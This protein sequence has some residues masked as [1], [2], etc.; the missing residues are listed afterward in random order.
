MI[1][2]YFYFSYQLKKTTNLTSQC[3]PNG[4]RNKPPPPPSI[5]WSLADWSIS[6]VVLGARTVAI[7]SGL[8]TPWRQRTNEQTYRIRHRVKALLASNVSSLFAARPMHVVMRCLSVLLSVR[9][10][11]VFCRNE[12]FFYRRVATPI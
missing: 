3:S 8:P 4:R 7:I 10:V 2:N 1:V 12:N 9:H 5:C 11:R 6:A